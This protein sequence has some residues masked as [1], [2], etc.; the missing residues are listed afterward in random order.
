MKEKFQR[1]MMGRYGTD[2]L[3]RFL[4]GS[5]VVLLVISMFMR[6]GNMLY[7]FALLLILICY[8]RMFS[9]NLQARYN[10]NVK[11]YNMKNRVLG[12]WNKQKSYMAQRKTHHIYKCPTCRQKIRVPKGKGKIMIT[13]PKCKTEFMKN[14]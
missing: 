3:N 4:L 6:R 9:R 11:F 12:F 14:S 13:C 10:E 2:S 7:S 5:S 1:F 8:V